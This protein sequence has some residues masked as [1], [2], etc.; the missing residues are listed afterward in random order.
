MS[1]PG[2]FLGI[3][4]ST[5]IGAAFHVWRGGSLIRMVLYIGLSWL[6]FWAGHIL[7]GALSWDFLTVGS[8][9]LGL[10]VI[11]ALIFLLAGYWLSLVQVQK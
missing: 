11:T 9:H 8:L 1:I 5:L 2:I 7:A 3:I 10:A 6:G 4:V